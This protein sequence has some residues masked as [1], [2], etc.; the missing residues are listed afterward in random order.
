MWGKKWARGGCFLGPKTPL[1][2]AQGALSQGGEEDHRC[3]EPLPPGP[4]A[5][6][7]MARSRENSRGHKVALSPLALSG[8]HPHSSLALLSC[9]VVSARC[10]P[11]S[12]RAELPPLTSGE[13]S[14]GGGHSIP[15]RPPP[16]ADRKGGS[17]LGED[18]RRGWT[19]RGL[20]RGGQWARMWGGAR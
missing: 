8:L 12:P 1:L 9:H 4:G 14:W 16:G 20:D 11:A 10:P 3:P 18:G 15:P 19:G 5:G 7:A 13:P 2:Q 17:A 6:C